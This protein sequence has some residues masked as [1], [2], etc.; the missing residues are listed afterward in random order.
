MRVNCG[1]YQ[2]L[3][4]AVV[5]I[6]IKYII[7]QMHILLIINKKK[8]PEDDPPDNYIIASAFQDNTRIPILDLAASAFP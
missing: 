8:Y 7:T 4:R 6:I 5:N 3:S 2:L 1:K